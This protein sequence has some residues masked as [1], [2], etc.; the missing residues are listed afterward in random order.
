MAELPRSAA[1]LRELAR[2]MPDQVREGYRRGRAGGIGPSRTPRRVVLLG[3]GGSA[4]AGDLVSALTDAET[5]LAL[6]V[7]RGPTLPG[8][9]DK[10]TLAIAVSYSGSTAETRAAYEEAGRRG[11]PRIVVTSGGDLAARATAEGVPLLALPTGGPPRAYVGFVLGALLG[12]L[13]PAFS[14]S[15][16]QRLETAAAA[17]AR[18][19]RAWARPSGPPARWARRVGRRRITV[20]ADAGWTGLARRWKTQLE[21]NAKRLASYESAP[22][23]FHNAIVPWS[24][25]PRPSARTEAM[26]R[27]DWAGDPPEIRQ[28]F[29]YLGGQVRPQGAPEV[30]VPLPEEDR[31]A[32]LLRGL[33]LGDLFSLAVAD[34]AGID[35]YPIEA[36]ERMKR[37]LG[38]GTPSTAGP[39]LEPRPAV[40]AL[41]RKRIR[42]GPVPD[43]GMLR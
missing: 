11:C 24:E 36:I 5:T 29:R 39:A 27:L 26:V 14:P 3:M 12:V 32:A 2:Q 8:S 28:R 19:W 22:E 10:G 13:A 20:A 15:T 34:D 25:L 17:V 30:V 31:L 9:M 38:P 4:I 40:P 43:G 18:G 23:L 6:G 16:G 21:E 7:V 35:P 42:G 41:P 1:R 33:A 37:R